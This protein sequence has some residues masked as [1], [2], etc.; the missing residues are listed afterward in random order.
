MEALPMLTQGKGT[1]IFLPTEAAGAMGAIGA[2][3]RVM[4]AAG[5]N[6]AV[7][8]AFKPTGALGLPPGSGAKG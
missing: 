6:N 3:R 1:T 5:Q 7:S 4:D 2:L 8:E